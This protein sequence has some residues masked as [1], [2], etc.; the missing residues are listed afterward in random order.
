[1]NRTTIGRWRPLLLLAML[2]LI[3]CR[4]D[5][6][7]NPTT[8]APIPTSTPTPV[9]ETVVTPETTRNP[10]FITIVIDAPSRFRD[11][12]DIDQFGNV[13]G[14][15]AEVMADLAATADFDYDVEQA[16]QLLDEAGLVDAD[17]DGWRD[18]PSGK[19][20]ELIIDQGTWGGGKEINTLANESF[21][22]DLEALG[23]KAIIN[24]LIDQPD[25][26]LRQ[27]EALY[28][29]RN[30]GTSELDIWTYPDW[31]FPV[32]DNRA[33]P[34]QGKWRQTG[35]AEGEKPEP[36]SP[37]A[38]L[39]ELYDKGLAEPDPQKRHE[40]VWEAVQIHIDEGPFML[41]VA[42]DQPLPTTVNEGF[43]NVPRT[44]ILG[45]WAPGSPGNKFPEQFYISSSG[46]C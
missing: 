5:E 42:G 15:D 17:G 28:M 7:D 45:P 20:F 44:G 34:M 22:E 6:A 12:A 39:Q 16:K 18:L 1:M 24:N 11:F 38:R 8:Q 41:G 21:R 35:G 36:G 37:A 40:I 10:N 4:D 25:W 9:A 19:P 43:C 29:L 31:V 33:F 14:F 30:A 13:I 27:D 26:Q 3:G 46:S 23:V 32:R 2:L